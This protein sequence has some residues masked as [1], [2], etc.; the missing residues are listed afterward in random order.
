MLS[1]AALVIFI[2]V[3][4]NTTRVISRHHAVFAEFE[5]PT[6]LKALVWLYPIP[7]VLSFIPL[8]PLHLIAFRCT[9]VARGPCERSGT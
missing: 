2:A 3:A 8:A 5:Q 1:I 7:A 9:V 6:V 4:S